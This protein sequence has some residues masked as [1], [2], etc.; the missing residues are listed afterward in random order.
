MRSGNMGRQER[1]KCV[2]AWLAGVV[3]AA[4]AGALAPP[5]RAQQ[6]PRQLTAKERKKQY[7]RLQQELGGYYKKWLNGVVSYIIS[8]QERKAFLQ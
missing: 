4:C 1:R 3:I 6:H 7:K 8:P 2:A 5:L